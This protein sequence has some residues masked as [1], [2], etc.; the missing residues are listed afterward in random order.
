MLP[1]SVGKALGFLPF[2]LACYSS[3]MKDR[4]ALYPPSE[5]NKLNISV[6]F[7]GFFQKSKIKD[8]FNRIYPSFTH[9]FDNLLNTMTENV[10][11]EK[12]INDAGLKANILHPPLSSSTAKGLKLLK[13]KGWLD[14]NELQTFTEK[15]D[16]ETRG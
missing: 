2:Y 11:F 15:L 9:F 14:E 12:K 13:K 3:E 8:I 6:R 1:R 5:V 16:L 7:K 4:Y 10:M